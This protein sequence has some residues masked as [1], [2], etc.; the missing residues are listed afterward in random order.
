MA[1]AS[2]DPE[3]SSVRWFGSDG[4]ANSE[5]LIENS[6][7]AEFAFETS[8]VCPVYGTLPG[9]LI[10]N[11]SDSERVTGAIAQKTGARPNGYGYAMASYDALW[12]AA[13]SLMLAKSQ[14][15]SQLKLALTGIG[16]RFTGITG[17]LSLN[18][19]GDRESVTYEFVTVSEMEGNHSWET[20]GDFRLGPSGGV[21]NWK[22][23]TAKLSA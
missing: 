2:R 17:P 21:L 5:G 12:V 9:Q 22:G 3:L 15:P 6:T 7:A 4:I 18:S 14:S 1:L 23:E 13:Q 19:A 8:L 10:R 11:M 16:G 20:V